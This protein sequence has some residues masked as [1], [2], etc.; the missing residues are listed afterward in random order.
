MQLREIEN[1]DWL[2][3]WK[4][5]WQPVEVGRFIVAPT[6]SEIKSVRDRI[7]IRI[8]R[9]WLSARARMKLRASA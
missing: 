6:W 1:Q 4:Q 3:E 7:V 8:D 9:V 2:A 5:N